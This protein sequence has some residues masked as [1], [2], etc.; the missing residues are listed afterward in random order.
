MKR[1][2][3][4][5]GSDDYDEL[6]KYTLDVY[7]GDDPKKS[8]AALAMWEAATLIDAMIAP[9]WVGAIWRARGQV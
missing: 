6:E 5:Y 9:R 1:E 2:P 7:L 3:F 4:G 8:E